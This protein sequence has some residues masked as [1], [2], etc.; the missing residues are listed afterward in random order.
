MK[1]MANEKCSV[2]YVT[3]TKQYLPVLTD[4]F[5]AIILPPNT[6]NPVHST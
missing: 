1:T 5:W 6:A 4:I 2:R 3:E